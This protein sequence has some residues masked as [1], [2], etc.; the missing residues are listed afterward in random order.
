MK[1]NRCKL[2]IVLALM[3]FLMKAQSGI[4]QCSFQYISN[5]TAHQDYIDIVFE[6]DSTKN[7]ISF[8]SRFSRYNTSNSIFNALVFQKFSECGELL[9]YNANSTYGSYLLRPERLPYHPSYYPEEF[10][11][12]HCLQTGQDRFVCAVK[13]QDSISRLRYVML[14]EI[15]NEGEFLK[16]GVS[17]ISA[18]KANQFLLSHLLQLANKQFIAILWD[19]A[20]GYEFLYF[21]EAFEFQ[22]AKTFTID[23][24]IRAIKSLPNGDFICS[25]AASDKYGFQFYRMDSLAQIK[26]IQTPVEVFGSIRDFIVQNDSIYLVGNY[27]NTAALLIADL[28][29]KILQSYLYTQQPYCNQRFCSVLL[30]DDQ[31]ASVGAYVRHCDPDDP[32]GADLAIFTI[33]SNGSIT[34]QESYNFIS[35]LGN[36]NSSQKNY[37]TDF[38]CYGLTKTLD[39][40]LLM[41]GTSM[42][43]DVNF[44]AVLHHDALLVKTKPQHVVQTK[45]QLDGLSLDIK[46]KTNLVQMNWN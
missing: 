8:G 24:G 12:N 20:T 1:S 35:R 7:I 9:Q 28:N 11:G 41:Y 36:G 43:S 31:S 23:R 25:A 42:Y 10:I 26:W 2:I 4:S 16:H 17:P 22:Y 46:L 15:N 45:N 21:D 34:N 33:D 3:A 44:N 38:G 32:R 39:Q 27:G 14:V 13:V 18:Q 5:D 37:F 40:G 19:L 30:N 29:G 6:E